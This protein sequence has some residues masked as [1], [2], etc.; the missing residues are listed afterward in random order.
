M[1]GLVRETGGSFAEVSR[2][3]ILEAWKLLEEWHGLRADYAG[4]AALAG[5]FRLRDEG[6]I[7]PSDKVLVNLTGG[8]RSPGPSV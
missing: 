1:L 4:A 8:M 3:Q 6:W 5:A 2:N 7:K